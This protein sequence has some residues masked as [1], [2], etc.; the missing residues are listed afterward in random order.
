[1]ITEYTTDL[2][3][4]LYNTELQYARLRTHSNGILFRF[5]KQNIHRQTIVLPIRAAGHLVV[6]NGNYNLC[7]FE[8]FV[9]SCSPSLR[10]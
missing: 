1:M 8:R 10:Y 7:V 4:A 6:G 2:C 5:C 9:R 3:K